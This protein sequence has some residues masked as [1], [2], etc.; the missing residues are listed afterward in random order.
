MSVPTT[1]T[2]IS[3]GHWTM[4]Q[5][6]SV[7]DL[8]QDQLLAPISSFRSETFIFETAPIGT[9]RSAENRGVLGP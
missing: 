3:H 7:A 2:G 1:D 5:N 4:P 9:S 8:A 6:C